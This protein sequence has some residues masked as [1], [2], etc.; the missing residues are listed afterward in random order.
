[1]VALGVRRTEAELERKWSS[2]ARDLPDAGGPQINQE[3]RK[4]GDNESVKAQDNV[5]RAAGLVSPPAPFDDRTGSTNA[6]AYYS[7]K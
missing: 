5:E 3:L 1:M 4:S 2:A 7:E 6:V